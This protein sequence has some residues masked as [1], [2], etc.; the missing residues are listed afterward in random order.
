MAYSPLTWYAATGTG[1]ASAYVA[2]HV[3]VGQRRFDD[4][5]TLSDIERRFDQRFGHRPTVILLVALA[6]AGQR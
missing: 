5:G 6:I 3:Q 1:D 2:Q 4:D